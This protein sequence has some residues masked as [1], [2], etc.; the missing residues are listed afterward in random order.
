MPL[1]GKTD[2]EISKPKYLSAAD[3]AKCFFVSTEEALLA[4][5]KSKGITGSGWWLINEYTDASGNKRYKSECLVALAVANAT[6]GDAADDA[7]VPDV[8]VVASISVQPTNQ[9]TVSGAA[10]FSVTGALSGGGSIA[11]QWQRAAAATPTRFVNVSGATSASL[12]LAGRTIANDGDKYRVVISG[13]G[14]KA[15]NSSAATLTFGD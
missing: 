11:Y 14:A 2:A 7:T 4:T 8:E 1:H 12:V 15:L 13:S 9:T 3:K 10:T 5:N 6:S